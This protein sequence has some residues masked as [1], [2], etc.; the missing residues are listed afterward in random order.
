MLNCSWGGHMLP[1]VCKACLDAR[2]SSSIGGS[3]APGIV[4]GPAFLLQHLRRSS[5]STALCC[6]QE[7][8]WDAEEQLRGIA[9]QRA[10]QEQ[11]AAA[12]AARRPNGTAAPPLARAESSSGRS[13]LG[14]DAAAAGRWAQRGSAAASRGSRLAEEGG[15]DAG[16]AEDG[17]PGGGG[18]AGGMRVGC[19]ILPWA[20]QQNSYAQPWPC[21]LGRGWPALCNTAR[22]ATLAAWPRLCTHG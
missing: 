9:A 20:R 12:A 13:Q 2:R 14:G 8:L 22:R 16:E 19:R 17:A 15:G 18:G 7:R 11:A 3:I 5:N 6:A 1:L 21:E 4:L 10:A